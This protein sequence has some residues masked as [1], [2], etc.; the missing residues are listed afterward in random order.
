MANLHHARP[1][2]TD[3]R[4]SLPDGVA[5]TDLD[6]VEE[7]LI[8]LDSKH[9]VQ[10]RHRLQ[11]G[12]LESHPAHPARTAAGRPQQAPSAGETPPGRDR[13]P[14]VPSPRAPRPRPCQVEQRMHR[15][16]VTLTVRIPGY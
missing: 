2:E 6:A 16:L 5:P 13:R 4:A 1:G 14:A 15:P 7:G 11:G 10:H 12:R 9:N 8:P 3:I